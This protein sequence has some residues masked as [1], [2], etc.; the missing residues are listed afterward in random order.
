MRSQQPDTD[1]ASRKCQGRKAVTSKQQEYSID[2]SDEELDE[3]IVHVSVEEAP[4]QVQNV[5][6]S[7]DD[8]KEYDSSMDT[9]ELQ[10]VVDSAEIPSTDAEDANTDRMDETA[11]AADDTLQGSEVGVAE[12]VTVGEQSSED[13]EDIDKP[14][15]WSPEECMARPRRH[16]KPVERYGNPILYSQQASQPSSTSDWIARVQY[17]AGLIGLYPQLEQQLLQCIMHVVITFP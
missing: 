3:Y 9:K 16:C 15:Q 5:A 17:L 11:V 7:T 4:G 2:V 14:G 8:I 12:A 1:S 13:T 6:L 10:E